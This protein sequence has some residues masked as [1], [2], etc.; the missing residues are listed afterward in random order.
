MIASMT[1][2]SEIPSFREGDIVA[3]KTEPLM[4]MVV[5]EIRKEFM[6]PRKQICCSWFNGRSGRA[7]FASAW[8]A[9]A[10]LQHFSADPEETE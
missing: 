2:G 8:F 4:K 9:A 3:H 10:E 1:K 5:A 7:E 6:E